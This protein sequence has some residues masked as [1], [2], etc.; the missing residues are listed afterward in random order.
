MNTATD[1]TIDRS[2]PSRRVSENTL[3]TVRR[4]RPPCA[5]CL[6]LADTRGHLRVDLGSRKV[7]FLLEG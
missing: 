5:E 7:G 1:D 6:K 3:L 2:H 4:P